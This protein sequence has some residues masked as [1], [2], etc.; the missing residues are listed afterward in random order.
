MQFRTK[1]YDRVSGDVI[2]MVFPS[3][4]ERREHIRHSRNYHVRKLYSKDYVKALKACGG[5]I[6]KRIKSVIADKPL[7]PMLGHSYRLREYRGVLFEVDERNR[8]KIIMKDGR[9]VEGDGVAFTLVDNSQ[10]SSSSMA[11]DRTIE[12]II[13]NILNE[14]I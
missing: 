14:S 12:R 2:V 13:N 3:N 8:Y 1:E 6:D 11:Q 10:Q 5:K 4:K 9:T 7:I